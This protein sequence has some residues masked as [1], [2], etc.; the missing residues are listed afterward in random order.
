MFWGPHR[1]G[2]KLR[3]RMGSEFKPDWIDGASYRLSIGP[4]LYISPTGDEADF[5]SR[6]IVRLKE[7]EGF[8]I[9]PGQF[10]VLQT[11][12]RVRVERDEVAFM[13]IRAKTKYRGLVNVSGFHVDPGFSG[14][15]TFAIF[16]AGPV[17]VHLRR[18]QDIFL[19]W[20]ANLTDPA[21]KSR[22]PA[23][24]WIPSDLISS[25]GAGQLHSLTGLAG[26]MEVVRERLDRRLDA[27]MGELAI[28]RVVAAIAVT[29]LVAIGVKAFGGP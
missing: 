5:P 20:Y 29:A 1:L 19:I 9:P 27:V 17:A 26:A 25:I 18:G 3:V 14:R 7:K 2:R 28:F 12:E 10:A 13:S 21:E 8:A 22:D 24:D 6:S 4:D 11:E 16:N 15:L 23:P